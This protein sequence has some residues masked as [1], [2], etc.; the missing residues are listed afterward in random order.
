MNTRVVP[1]S[2]VL[3]VSIYGCG[4]G[5]KDEIENITEESAIRETGDDGLKG[6][7]EEPKR[8]PPEPRIF[9]TGGSVYAPATAS[10]SVEAEDFGCGVKDIEVSVDGKDFEAYEDPIRFENEGVHTIEY[11]A[12]DYVGNVT[13]RKPYKVT[14]DK[15]PPGT[16]CKIVPKPIKAGKD[17]CVL[18]DCKV[19]LYAEDNLSGI[20]RTLYKVDG[21]SYVEYDGQI[22]LPDPGSH[23]IAFKSQDNVGTWEIEKSFRLIVDGKKPESKI[24]PSGPLF[25][26]ENGRWAPP[27]HKYYLSATDDVIGVEEIRYSINGAEFSVYTNPIELEPGTHK[28]LYYAVDRAHNKEETNTFEVKVDSE[29]PLTTVDAKID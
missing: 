27:T 13:P 22:N 28:I 20:W 3:F 12:C 18:P 21:G 23:I 2:L 9:E 14:I 4:A 15:T 7:I 19:Y 10:F 24:E 16:E 29:Y 6:D 1:I 8:T 25:E 26:S 5:E 17:L 11:K